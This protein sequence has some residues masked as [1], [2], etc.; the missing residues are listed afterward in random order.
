MALRKLTLYLTCLFF[1]TGCNSQITLPRNLEESV[2]Y[3]QQK[4][5]KTQ[6]DEFKNTAEDNAVTEHHFGTGSWIRNNWIHGDRDTTL[7]NYFHSLGI[8]HPDDISSIILTSLHRTLNQRDIQL[9]KQVEKYKAYW[10]PIIDCKQKQKAQAVTIFNKFKEGDTI[11]ISMPVD[12]SY[13]GRT[14]VLYD[15]PTAE[16]TFDKGKDLIIKGTVT[17]KY[18]INDTANVFFTIRIQYMNRKDTEI[19]MTKVKTGEQKDFPLTAL[20]IE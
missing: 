5:T 13:G 8:F 7:T 4:W 9:N 10:G 1:M 2:L 18:F 6:L 3:F 12:T 20:K 19:L 11:T 14:A 17:R 15:C 16:W